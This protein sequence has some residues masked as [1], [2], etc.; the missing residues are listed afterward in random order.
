MDMFV[1]PWNQHLYPCVVEV[2]R[3]EL[4]P[5]CD[6][7]LRHSV[8]LK[9][10][11]GCLSTTV[12]STRRV[13]K[14]SF[15]GAVYGNKTQFNGEI[16]WNRYSKWWAIFQHIHLLN[17]DICHTV[18]PT[19]ESLCLRSLPPGIITTVTPI[20]V[21]LSPWKRWRWPERIF[22]RCKEKI[23]ISLGARSGLYGGWL[24]T[25]QL[26]SCT[27]WVDRQAGGTWEGV[28]RTT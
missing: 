2:C 26:N 28:P 17:W 23:Y 14:V 11:A 15:P 5:L 3:L 20:S 24:N 6:T 22:L 4:E 12:R 18:G 7:H 9:T 10:L 19:F 21:S 16:Y 13:H 25:S 8:F 27:R 1:I